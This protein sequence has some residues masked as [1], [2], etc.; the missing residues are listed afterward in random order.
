M[1]SPLKFLVAES[2]PPEARN[3]RRRSV[4]RSS[5]ETYLDVLRD[6]APDARCHRVK[7][8]D[9]C[10]RLPAGEALAGYDGVF[11]TGSPLH[12][13]EETSETRREIEFMRAI[14]VA[15]TPAFGSCAG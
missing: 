12:L 8:T 14:F 5:G 13:Y 3:R 11:L 2:E 10:S 9:G 6:I 7:P 4:G 15:G 1:Q